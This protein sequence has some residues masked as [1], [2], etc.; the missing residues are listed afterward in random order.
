MPDSNSSLSD[1]IDIINTLK[2]PAVVIICVVFIAIYFKKEIK[3]FFSKANK[4]SVKG[5]GMEFETG[6][7]QNTTVQEQVVQEKMSHLS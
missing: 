7:E 3:S 4:L 1:A 6:K 5:V 2:W